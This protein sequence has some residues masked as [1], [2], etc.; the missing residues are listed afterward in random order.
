M[1]F[2]G[3]P[4]NFPGFPALQVLQLGAPGHVA[5][6]RQAMFLAAQPPGSCGAAEPE[7]PAVGLA[8]MGGMHDG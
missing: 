1:L 3:F 5:P 2:H 8:V 7:A 6:H 4:R